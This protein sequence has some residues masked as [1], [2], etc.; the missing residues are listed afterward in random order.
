MKVAMQ[1]ARLLPP[2]VCPHPSP[3]Q[4]C[5]KDLAHRHPCWEVLTSP[6][7]ASSQTLS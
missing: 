5:P 2:G 4:S 3:T 6:H 1:V 7:L